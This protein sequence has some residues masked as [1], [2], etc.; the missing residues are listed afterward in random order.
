MGL[1]QN[2]FSRTGVTTDKD[3]VRTDVDGKEV[4][5]WRKHNRLQGWFRR[6]WERQGNSGE[7]NVVEVP[8]NKD[9][10]DR[11]QEDVESSKLP[12]EGGFFYGQDS[13]K[14]YH[15]EDDFE[16]ISKARKELAE[17]REVYYWS[18]W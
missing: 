14:N 3:N 17:G 16:A 2:F 5:Y 4:H 1:D 6:E 10:L 13:Y 8:I 15:M 9:L 7:F 11:L 12:E 18:W